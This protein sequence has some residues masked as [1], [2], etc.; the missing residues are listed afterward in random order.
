MPARKSRSRKLPPLPAG[1]AGPP[2]GNRYKEQF[3]VIVICPD[4]TTQRA[5]F[6][7][8]VG[9]RGCDLRVVTT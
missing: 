5:I 4:E 1:T 7:A 9:L 3:G 8:L 2:V 6:D